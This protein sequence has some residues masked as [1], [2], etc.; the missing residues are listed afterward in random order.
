MKFKFESQF[1]GF[2]SPKTT[3]E[4]EVDQLEDVLAYFKQFLEGCGYR[5]DG[6]LY[7]FDEETPDPYAPD[8]GEKPTKRELDLD[9]RC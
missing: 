6:E 5:I 9:G 7:I 8:V 4:V 3:M 1:I 2:G